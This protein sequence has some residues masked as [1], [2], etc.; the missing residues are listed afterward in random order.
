M[1]YHIR[2]TNWSAYQLLDFGE[3]W[4]WERWGKLKTIR[5]DKWAVGRPHQPRSFWQDSH[6]YTPKTAYEGVWDPP[7][8]E[9]WTITYQG[10]GWHMQLWCRSGKFKH[11]GIFPEQ[12]SHWDWLYRWVSQHKGAKVLNLFAYTG[13]ASIAA[14]LAGGK[15][16]H[17]DASRSAITWAVENAALNQL[18]TIRWLVEDARKFVQ[19]A[20]RR[21][22]VYDALLLDPPAYGISPESKRWEIQRD[23]PPL[24]EELLPLLPETH[25][26]FL[27]NL[28]SAD[29]SPYTLLRLIQEVRNIPL[30]IGELVLETPERRRLSTG[31]YVRGAW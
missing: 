25:G 28:Y 26:L 16:T 13:A 15:V 8:P 30:E 17:V 12:A 3:G 4:R 20:S 27:I 24:L 21:K 29:F 5:P 14:A 22:E 19:R 2:T 18:S 6:C 9:R 31:F 11:L 1:E 7:L 23:L 10:K